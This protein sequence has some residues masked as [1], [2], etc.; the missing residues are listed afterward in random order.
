[1]SV[2]TSISISGLSWATP[3][4]TPLFRDLDLTFG[5]G[6]WG[7]VGRNGSGKSTLLRL[8]AGEVLPHSGRVDVVGTVSLMRQRTR[9]NAGERIVD[10][11]GVGAAFDV[12]HRAEA[13]EA[14]AQDLADA[15]WTIPT[16]IEAA[17]GRCGMQVPPETP[18]ARLSGGEQSRAALAALV[19]ACPDFLLL[20]EPTNN[21]DQQ[22]RDGVAELVRNWTGGLL[23]ASHDRALL[24]EADGIIELTSLGVARYGGNYTAFHAQKEAERHAA[25]RELAH[26]GK[27]SAQAAQ[28]AQQ[29]AERKARKDSAG[30]KARGK[31]DQPKSLLDMAKGR[32]EASGGAGM[33]LREA[34]RED[35]QE[36]LQAAR[37]K[38]EVVAPL[39][40]SLETCGLSAGKNVL[41]V[42]GVTGGPVLARPVIRDLSLT[43]TGPERIAITGANG[44]GKTTLLNLITGQIPP[45][46]GQVTLG[47]PWALLDQHLGLLDE[48]HTIRQAFQCCSPDATPNSAHAALARFGFRASDALRKINQLSGGERV[49]VSL[50]CVLGAS[51]APQLLILDEPTNHLDLDGIN[52]LEAALLAYDGAVLAVSHDQT[53]LAALKPQRVISLDDPVGRG[54]W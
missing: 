52:A 21:L 10:L 18:L 15:D 36:A 16:R 22:G 39:R 38:I 45:E 4:G 30:R 53:F 51:P 19:F 35:A 11:F 40:M 37:E 25:Q 46:Q 33:R 44:S 43:I 54:S 3:E 34:R 42:Q 8:I 24:E 13:G 17:L 20:D 5:L 41:C 49:R 9:H 14:T 32:A 2:S 47:V 28:R 7:I 26:A 1:M 23:I 12:L 29:A 50:A 6:R 31:G 27:V 48:A